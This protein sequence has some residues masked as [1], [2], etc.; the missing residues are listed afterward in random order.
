MER[1]V[2]ES[3]D[4]LKNVIENK[5]NQLTES[6][7]RLKRKI[8]DLYTIFEISRKLGS[9]L[10]IDAL[11]EAMLLSLI[12]QLGLDGAAIFI[13][14]D[15]HKKELSMFK[16]KGIDLKEH[17]DFTEFKFRQ[18]S[19]LVKLLLSE[20][21]PLLLNEIRAHI[22]RGSPDFVLTASR[23]SVPR[24][25]DWKKE[26][27]VLEAFK[28]ELCIPLISKNQIRGILSLTGKT[29]GLPFTDSDLEFLSV[30][31]G[32]FTSAVENAI[33]YESQK[34][35]NLE[36]R[37]T[38]KQLIQ[39]EKLAALGRLSASIAHEI[40]N[41]LGIIKNY[42]LI[43]SESMKNNAP[44]QSNLKSVK[45]EVDRIARTVRSL[46]DFCRPKNENMST[47][48]IVEII[49]QTVFLVEKQF[50][51]EKCVIKKDLPQ[52]L[53]RVKGFNDE[54]K[55]VFLNLLMNAKDS[56]PQEGEILVLT[57][58]N[59]DTVEIEFSDTGCGIPEENIS[60]VFEPFFTTKEEGKGT[61]L[62]LWICYEIIQR[63]GGTIVAKRK[64]KGT[65]FLITLP[66]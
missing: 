56:M 44:S 18:D 21:G 33:L 53:P 29:S 62:G 39:S 52:N 46:L 61:G 5:V 60:R 36:L 25:K 19:D 32:Q 51:K 6:N 1:R 63:H 59:E 17:P 57:R 9:T 16:I 8:F 24:L 14:K 3:V 20:N 26:I 11:L 12:G 7:R 43:L 35:M 2:L 23:S 27:K 64:D 15:P 47:L 34:N 37:R 10:D 54:I 31:T 65:S 45:E 49:N 58:Q 48:D 28:C 13:Q 66:I 38:Q 50:L 42:L 22:K 40:N 30:L 55:Q 41:P 4:L